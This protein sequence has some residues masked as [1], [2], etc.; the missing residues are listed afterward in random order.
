MKKQEVI[1]RLIACQY[2][3][4]K[5]QFTQLELA[6]RTGMSLSTVNLAVSN[7]SK[8]NAV[9]IRTRSFAVISLERLLMF[10]ATRRNIADDIQYSTNLDASVKDIEG[11]MPDGIA[12]TAY[13][14]YKL[15]YKDVPADYSEVYVYADQ[16]GLEELQ[17]RFGHREGMPNL[18]VLKAD[19]VLAKE[20]KGNGLAHSS[21]CAAQVFVDL[22][23]IKAWYANDFVSALKARLGI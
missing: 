19:G 7:L 20:M 10:W 13:T 5:R 18:L 22:W 4:G 3:D 2:I 8:V 11:G 1:F 23:N 17:K 21:V 6:Q 15:L 12:F 16:D 9:S 14:A